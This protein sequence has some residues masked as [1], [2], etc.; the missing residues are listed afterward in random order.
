MIFLLRKVQVLEAATVRH[1]MSQTQRLMEVTLFFCSFSQ[2]AMLT[3]MHRS[4][5]PHTSPTQNAARTRHSHTSRHHPQA[6]SDV[7]S[8]PTRHSHT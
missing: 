8:P 1:W 5:S 2:A 3:G 4:L 7:T 6:Q